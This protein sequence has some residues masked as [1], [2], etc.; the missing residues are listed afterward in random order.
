MRAV[1]ASEMGN[2]WDA[3]HPGWRERFA[4]YFSERQE[5]GESQLFQARSGDEIVGMLFVSLVDDYHGYVRNKKSGRVNSVYVLPAFR[6]RG[7]ARALMLA[8]ID[9]IR[10]KGCVVVRLNSSEDG[11]ALYESL[12]FKP[13]REMEFSLE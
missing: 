7:V 11:I 1:M 12:G 6:R 8:G 5:A 9:W 10:T 2:N 3:D 13:R 4:L